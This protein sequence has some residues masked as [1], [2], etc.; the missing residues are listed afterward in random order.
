M[1]ENKNPGSAPI[2]HYVSDL[3]F[4]PYET[5]QL[6]A[7]QER[8]F[9]SSGWRLMW[10]KFR[11]HRLAVAAGCVLLALYG[12]ILISEFLA[13][14]ALTHRHTDFIYAPPQ[15]VHLFH[16]GRFIGPFVYG[17]KYKLNMENLRREYTVDTSRRYPLRFFCR[18]DA[19]DF[20]GLFE[21]SAHLVCPGKGGTMFLFGTD[22]LGRDLFSRIIYGARISLT[23]GL[24]GVTFSMILGIIFGGL[25]G[26]YGGILDEALMRALDTYFAIPFILLALVAVIVFG[27]SVTVMLVLLAL[28][29]WPPFVRN[30]R[31]EVLSLKERDYVAAARA[32][33]ASDIWIMWKHIVPN[34]INTVIVIATLRVGQLILAEAILSF[35][36]A[37]VPPPTPTWGAMVAEGRDYLASAWWISFFPGVM[38]FLLVMSMNLICDWFRD[39]FD[40]RLRNSL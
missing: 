8:L 39:R 34:V 27:Q 21:A 7:E 23:V 32:T 13:P 12:S 40:P 24:F 5:E 26:Y 10:I 28:L 2:A 35:L 9:T 36:G 22:R 4:D 33:G 16:E 14:Y 11:R 30:V 29:A 18:G 31:A 37:G 17:F 20:W 6:S 3:P 25:A 38:I 15:R 19:Y 1:T